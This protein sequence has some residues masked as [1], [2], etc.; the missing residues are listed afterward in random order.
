M[1]FIVSYFFVL[2]RFVYSNHFNDDIVER[3][4]GMGD[5]V[6]IE[7]IEI[8]NTISSKASDRGFKIKEILVSGK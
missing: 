3:F 1:A 5:N 2:I 7:I 8:G 4:Y 6:K